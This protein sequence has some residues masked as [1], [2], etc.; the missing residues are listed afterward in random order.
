M[1]QSGSPGTKGTHV[2]KPCCQGDLRRQITSA[3]SSTPQLLLVLLFSKA[4]AA[5]KCHLAAAS[6]SCCCCCQI[7]DAAAAAIILLLPLQLSQ[8]RAAAAAA[9]TPSWPLPLVLL[10]HLPGS[11]YAVSACSRTAVADLHSTAQHITAAPGSIKVWHVATQLK[12]TRTH[13]I[14]QPQATTWYL[15]RCPGPG[16][17]LCVQAAQLSKCSPP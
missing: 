6:A 3:C 17:N 8:Q 1:P 5:A 10:P 2:L 12:Q 14:A 13:S 4:A 15:A 11:S 16:D 7:L 9:V